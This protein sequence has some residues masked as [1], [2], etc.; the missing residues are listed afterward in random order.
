MISLTLLVITLLI[1]VI[2]TEDEEKAYKEIETYHTKAQNNNYIS[3]YFFSFLKYKLHRFK[4]KR[5][6]SE[7]F[8]AW[9]DYKIFYEQ[10][11]IQIRA[12]LKTPFDIDRF[13]FNLFEIWENGILDANYSFA[14]NLKNISESLVPISESN[15]EHMNEYKIAKQNSFRMHN[16]AKIMSSIGSKF[17]INGNTC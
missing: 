6:I 13:G 11:A 14:M 2:L 9:N 10:Y 4:K 17:E 12:G 8:M 1:H 5:P 3:F 15:W 16:L 7:F